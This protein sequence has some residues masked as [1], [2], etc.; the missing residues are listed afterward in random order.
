MAHMRMH[1][2]QANGGLPMV[3]MRC[4]DPALVVKSKKLSYY[5]RGL[6]F[7][8]L[9]GA[10]GLVLLLILALAL[11]KT[12]LL[13]A[14]LCERHQGHWTIRAVISW[15]GTILVVLLCTAGLAFF[16]AL[17]DWRQRHAEDLGGLVCLASLGVF[18]VWLIVLAVLQ[19][20]AIRPDEITR[21]HI[22]LN[23]VSDEFVQA[24]E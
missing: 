7:L 2:D 21:T 5:P 6:L 11:R 4:G 20:T 19:N 15:A 18:V 1:V 16:I 10:P 13:Q 22:L 8:V 24:V 12:A 14:P 23:G 9:L 17:I 3:C